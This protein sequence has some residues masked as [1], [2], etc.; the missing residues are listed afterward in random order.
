MGC[1]CV[2][3][4]RRRI[5]RDK[6]QPEIRLRSQATCVGYCRKLV[7]FNFRMATLIR[8]GTLIGIKALVNK[9]SFEEAFLFKRGWLLEGGC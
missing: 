5:S 7:L 8:M 6:R 4:E 9:S 2:A 1:L 3:C